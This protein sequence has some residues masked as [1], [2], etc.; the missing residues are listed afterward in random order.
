[1]YQCPKQTIQHSS[2]PLFSLVCLTFLNLS[3]KLQYS[4]IVP[5]YNRPK[6]V[7]ELLESLTLLKGGIS[8]EVIIVEDGS[9]NTSEKIVLKYREKL[10][11]NYF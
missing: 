2:I 4:I 9:P 8:F 11:I 1:M 6:E 3:M 5:V 10:K 7:D